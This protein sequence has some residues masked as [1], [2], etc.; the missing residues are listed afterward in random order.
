MPN[1]APTAA[2][3]PTSP[4]YAASAGGFEGKSYI[5]PMRLVIVLATEAGLSLPE[6]CVAAATAYAESSLNAYAINRANSNGTIDVG[7]WQ[8][9]SVHKPAAQSLD[10]WIREIMQLK[11]NAAAMA[12][13]SAGGTR[14]GD[15]NGGGGAP[16][17]AYGTDRFYA[18]L[19]E[20]RKE[21]QEM[22]DEAVSVGGKVITDVDLGLLDEIMEK[23]GGAAGALVD[24]ATGAA[25]KILGFTFQQLGSFLGNATIFLVKA[26]GK[27]IW[28]WGIAPVWH[29]SQRASIYYFDE[30]MS[31]NEAKRT[32]PQ[33]KQKGD[34]RTHAFTEGWEAT[35]DPV[36]DNLGPGASHFYYRP[37][38][39]I[40]ILFWS[41]GY[42]ILWRD[43][44]DITN[45]ARE[46]PERTPLGR[47]VNNVVKANAQ[48][49]LIE[50]G[51]VKTATKKKP[52]PKTSSAAIEQ[53]GTA[54]TQRK[55]PI[56][57]ERIPA[58]VERTAAADA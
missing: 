26:A 21:L 4:T 13:I 10:A 1:V 47:A 55:R 2:S 53:T 31:G 38:A 8:I 20:A 11:N 7:L 57:T 58:G 52:T 17:Y 51:K 46:M 6:A 42:G 25:K 5:V 32:T 40:T 19:R 14:W 22:K 27:G 37:A 45:S 34:P 24:A 43:A 12:R 44:D 15:P 56:T 16:W 23:L 54:T 35:G 39:I 3:R 41:I 48:R 50:P 33:R 28:N 9:N 29:H 30:I 36:A 18:G 49:K